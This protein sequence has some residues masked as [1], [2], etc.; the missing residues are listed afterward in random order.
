[1]DREISPSALM[2]PGYL[3]GAIVYFYDISKLIVIK[4]GIRLGCN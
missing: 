3:S 1:M 2:E 4:M